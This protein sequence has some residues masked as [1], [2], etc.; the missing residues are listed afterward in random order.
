[1]VML[2]NL[3]VKTKKENRGGH[4]SFSTFFMSF[5]ASHSGCQALQKLGLHSQHR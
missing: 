3:S 1:M 4:L 2:R 5:A